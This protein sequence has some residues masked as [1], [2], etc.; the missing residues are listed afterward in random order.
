MRIT[1]FILMINSVRLFAADT[2]CKHPF[3]PPIVYEGDDYRFYKYTAKYVPENLLHCFKILATCGDEQLSVFSKRSEQEVIVQGMFSKGFRLRKE[4]CLDG[5]SPFVNF[6]HNRG[7]YYP[8]AMKTY[9]LLS[10]HQY[11]NG[12]KI[13][14]QHNKNL[15]LEDRKEL[16]KAWKERL[17]YVFDPIILEEEPAAIQNPVIMDQIEEQFF[18]Y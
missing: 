16:N 17:K 12:K 6:F 8:Y 7:I 10:F 2:L 15:A 13:R 14:W 11:L 1:F 3:Y 4:F 18:K 5:Y 9:I